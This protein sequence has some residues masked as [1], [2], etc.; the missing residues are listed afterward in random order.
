[1][2]SFGHFYMC[3]RNNERAHHEFLNPAHPSY[4]PIIIL[5]LHGG[6]ETKKGEKDDDIQIDT[7][8]WTLLCTQL[9]TN[10]ASVYKTISD[11]KRQPSPGDPFEVKK[12]TR[13][14]TRREPHQQHSQKSEIF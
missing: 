6:G 2:T 7:G 4:L 14:R 10:G 12:H 3:D 5:P 9:Y 1:M 8:C 13:E 11:E